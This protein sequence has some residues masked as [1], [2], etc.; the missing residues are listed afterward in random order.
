MRTLGVVIFVH[1]LAQQ[2]AEMAL[3][4]DDYV[5]KEVA[6]YSADDTFDERRLPRTSVTYSLFGDTTALEELR[7][8]LTIDLVVVTEHILGLPI[9]GHRF[10]KLLYGPF[11]R[12]II[13]QGPVNEPPTRVFDYHEYIEDSKADRRYREEVHRPGLCHV[14]TEEGAPGLGVPS[15][16]PALYHVFPDRIGTRWTEPEESQMA[17]DPFGAPEDVLSAEPSDEHLHVATDRRPTAFATRFPPPPET[18]CVSLPAD[19]SVWLHQARTRMPPGP[20]LREYRPEQSEGRIESWQR[21]LF[22]HDPMLIDGQL[23]LEGDKLEADGRSCSDERGEK[24][25]ESADDQSERK[26]GGCDAFV[27]ALHS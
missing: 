6:P 19:D 20:Q 16:A 18:E 27:E 25:D 10:A 5:V 9:E 1:V 17:M 22:L 23:A 4:E 13:G 2:R 7:D 15:S 14:I 12:W 8:F 11:H 21:F 26:G 24:G 3:A